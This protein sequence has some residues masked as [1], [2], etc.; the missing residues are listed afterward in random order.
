MLYRNIVSVFPDHYWI[1]LTYTLKC[2][3]QVMRNLVE[4]DR[5]SQVKLFACELRLRVGFS[6]YDSVRVE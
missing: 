4:K 6:K 1:G 2:L 3:L 5:V